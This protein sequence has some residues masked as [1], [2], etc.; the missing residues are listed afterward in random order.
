LGAAEDAFLEDFFL[1]F[2]GASSVAGNSA[3]DTAEASIEG[4]ATGAEGTE[5]D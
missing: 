5:G 4:G 3:S 1:P 2:N